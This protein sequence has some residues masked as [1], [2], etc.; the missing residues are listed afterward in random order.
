MNENSHVTTAEYFDV[1]M[2][3]EQDRIGLA[4]NAPVRRKVCKL[5]YFLR[6]DH[7]S[8]SNA[9]ASSSQRH[10]ITCATHGIQMLPHSE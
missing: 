8:V 4:D 2:D 5:R 6:V 10:V 1:I 9:I 7:T 3:T